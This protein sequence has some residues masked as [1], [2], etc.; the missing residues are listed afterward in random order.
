M[1]Q[2]LNDQQWQEIEEHLFAGRKIQA[3]KLFREYAGV[4]LKAAKDTLDE[5]EAELRKQSPEKFKF[6]AKSGC[7]GSFAVFL[8]FV[9]V[10][11]S[12]IVRMI[13]K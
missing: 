7:V 13:L 4:D 2:E 8:V 3:I 12:L 6:A 5:H 9:I 1:P 10:L 11:S